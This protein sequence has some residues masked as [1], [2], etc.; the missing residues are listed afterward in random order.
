MIE[1][2]KASIEGTKLLGL[3]TYLA[4]FL[5]IGIFVTAILLIRFLIRSYERERQIHQQFLSEAVKQNTSAIETVADR[6][7]DL[8][9]VFSKITESLTRL[10]SADRYQ[11]EEHKQILLILTELKNEM[12]NIHERLV[13]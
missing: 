10:E 9:G 2:I 6:M 7:N 8:A 5:S 13:K 4:L 11:R 1:L 3:S 12:S